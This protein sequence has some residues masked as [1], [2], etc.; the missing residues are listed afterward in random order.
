MI[1]TLTSLTVVILVLL[2]IDRIAGWMDGGYIK[3]EYVYE[4]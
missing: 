2:V 4:G 3:K 1:E